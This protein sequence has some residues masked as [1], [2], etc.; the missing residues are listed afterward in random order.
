MKLFSWQ[1]AAKANLD[2][3]LSRIQS[4]ECVRIATRDEKEVMV[5]TCTSLATVCDDFL[6]CIVPVR[7]CNASQAAH[8]DFNGLGDGAGLDAAIVV[9]GA[10]PEDTAE[11]LVRIET[12]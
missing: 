9:D 1:R 10:E 7:V 3:S 4:I 6:N 12:V 2:V 5:S 11:M 8:L